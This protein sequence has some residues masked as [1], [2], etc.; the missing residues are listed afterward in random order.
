[1]ANGEK[2]TL[3]RAGKT[4]KQKE[5]ERAALSELE[6][7]GYVPAKHGFAYDVYCDKKIYY[8]NYA[9]SAVLIL[10]GF[11][12]WK[13]TWV[14]SALLWFYGVGVAWTVFSETRIRIHVEGTRFTLSGSK[15][16]GDYDFSQVDK[17]TYTYNKKEQRRYEIYVDGKRICKIA[18]GSFNNRFLYDDM[19]AYGVPGGWINKM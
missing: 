14:G 1:M 11:I 7:K 2:K 13:Y 16:A 18:P 15:F 19:I 12:I 3:R 8:N 9:L 5:A 17:I 6:Q 10:F 4:K